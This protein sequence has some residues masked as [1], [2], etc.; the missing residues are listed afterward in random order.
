MQANIRTERNGNAASDLTGQQEGEELFAL[1]TA[2]GK[3]Q[4]QGG[5]CICK[6][7]MFPKLFTA[8]H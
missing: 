1:V 8:P 6:H 2:H 7:L 5:G 4:R 3:A